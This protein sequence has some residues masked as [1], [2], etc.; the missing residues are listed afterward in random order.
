MAKEAI[1]QQLVAGA[2]LDKGL[3]K[4]LKPL[5]RGCALCNVF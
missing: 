3:D 5:V 2:K 1:V 4:G